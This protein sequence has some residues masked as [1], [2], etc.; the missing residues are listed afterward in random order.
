MPALNLPLNPQDK[1][2]PCELNSI[3]NSCNSGMDL[4]VTEKGMGSGPNKWSGWQL[5]VE[6]YDV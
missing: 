6:S 3:K 5:P 2:A 1:L 4:L